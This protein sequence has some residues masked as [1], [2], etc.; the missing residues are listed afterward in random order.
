MCTLFLSL[1]SFGQ[2]KQFREGGLVGV[3]QGNLVEETPQRKPSKA[4]K[5]SMYWRSGQ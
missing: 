2:A 1:L 5:V 3:G 4:G